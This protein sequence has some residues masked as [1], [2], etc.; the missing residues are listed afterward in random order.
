KSSATMADFHPPSLPQGR[1]AIALGLPGQ[2]AF[3]RYTP[4]HPDHR[5]PH[6]RLPRQLAL[7]MFVAA[8]AACSSGPVRRISEPAA[9]IQQLTVQ[10]DGNWS[11]DL[12]LQNYSSIPM[13]FERLEFEVRVGDQSA[14]TLV[15]QPGLTIGGESADVATVAFAPTSN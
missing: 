15:A 4:A 11:V 6:V 1:G 3:A 7:W 13:R 12:R 8:L 2:P 5:R 10:A 14:G 9:S